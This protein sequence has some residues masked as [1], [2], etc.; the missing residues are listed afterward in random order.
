[1]SF[2]LSTDPT[3]PQFA[4]QTRLFSRKEPLEIPFV[5]EDVVRATVGEVRILEE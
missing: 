5:E 4:D 3:S 2:S 1:M